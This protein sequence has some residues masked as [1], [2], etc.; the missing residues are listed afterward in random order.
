MWQP[1]MDLWENAD[2]HCGQL[3]MEIQFWSF[4]FWGG[5]SKF[6]IIQMI[7][8]HYIVAQVKIDIHRTIPIEK[9]TDTYVNNI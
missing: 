9:Q 2:D 3:A 5:F 7:T 4:F 1:P 6:E 8:M